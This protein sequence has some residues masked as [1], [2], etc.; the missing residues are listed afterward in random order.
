MLGDAHRRSGGGRRIAVA[1]GDLGNPPPHEVVVDHVVVHDEGGVEQLERS[2]DVGCCFEVCSTE[3]PV[4]AEHRL[5]PEA[6]A[7]RGVLF[8]RFPELDVL[9]AEGCGPVLG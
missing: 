5:R 1:A 3:G 9:R 6:F 2:A 8:E 4:G 7:A